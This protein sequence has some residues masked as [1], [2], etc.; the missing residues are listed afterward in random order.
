VALRDGA[1][2]EARGKEY[3]IENLELPRGIGGAAQR[4]ILMYVE[5]LL[6][7]SVIPWVAP[8]SRQNFRMAQHIVEEVIKESEK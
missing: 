8:A 6:N 4:E 2:N 7:G 1:G 5:S 3:C